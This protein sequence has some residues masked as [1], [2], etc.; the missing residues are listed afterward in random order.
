MRHVT[1]T[2]S[3]YIMTIKR[4]NTM[5]FLQNVDTTYP[6]YSCVAHTTVNIFVIQDEFV[7]QLSSKTIIPRYHTH[8]T[9]NQFRIENISL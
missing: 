3:V 2:V 4:E 5:N 9:D 8:N 6:H 1:Q 7:I